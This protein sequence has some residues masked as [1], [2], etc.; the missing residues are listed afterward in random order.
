MYA[1]EILAEKKPN[2]FFL[3][4]IKES[5]FLSVLLLK[6]VFHGVQRKTSM[7]K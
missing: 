3:F 4:S 5:G 6:G 7:E 2:A 1:E